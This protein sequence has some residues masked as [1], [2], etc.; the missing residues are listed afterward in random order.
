[1]ISRAVSN[2]FC[3]LPHSLYV[4]Y[5]HH[6]HHH[7]HHHHH[8]SVDSS[9]AIIRAVTVLV[10]LVLQ[11]I[12]P[13]VIFLYGQHRIRIIFTVLVIVHA[14]NAGRSS[15][16]SLSPASLLS[17]APRLGPVAIQLLLLLFPHLLLLLLLL[18][19]ILPPFPRSLF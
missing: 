5:Y 8:H 4:E 10:L 3:G 18:R 6:H 13:L 15:G 7:Y 2:L 1:M 19:T 14:Y 16:A 17:I 12:R 9:S 11:L